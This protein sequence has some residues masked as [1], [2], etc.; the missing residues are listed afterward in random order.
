M[1]KIAAALLTAPSCRGLPG[2]SRSHR[3]PDSVFKA[4][5]VILQMIDLL[6]TLAG[7][8]LGFTEMNTVMRGLLGSPQHLAL[9]K[10]IIPLLIARFVPGRWL[11]PSIFLLILVVGWNVKE[12]LTLLL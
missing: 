9:T 8:S 10:L 2:L 3:P 1:I 7:T 4:A 11:L 6:L 5:Y 12:L